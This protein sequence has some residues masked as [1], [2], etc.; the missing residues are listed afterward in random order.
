[1]ALARQTV[2]IPCTGGVD[3]KTT[4]Q[5]VQPGSFLAVV[6]GEYSKAGAINKR[7]GFSKLTNTGRKNDSTAATLAACE[8]LAAFRDELICIDGTDLWS[9]SAEDAHW[10]LQDQIPNATVTRETVH[11]DGNQ[12]TANG[13]LSINQGI[14]VYAW[15]A[16]DDL[17]VR[18]SIVDLTT[19]TVL[20]SD[21]TLNTV[22]VTASAYP[23]CVA[24]GNFVFVIY[25]SSAN[26]AYYFRRIDVTAVTAGVGV[27]TSL[28]TGCSTQVWDVSRGP[29]TSQFTMSYLVAATGLEVTVFSTAGAVVSTATIGAAALSVGV[30]ASAN[31]VY[32]GW[33]TAA[34]GMSYRPYSTA[35]AP[36]A[37]AL[38]LDAAATSAC[39]IGACEVTS[40]TALFM[41]HL[42]ANDRIK[43]RSVNNAGAAL[44]SVVQYCFRVE[45][46]SKPFV[47]GSQIFAWVKDKAESAPQI[48]AASGYLVEVRLDQTAASNFAQLRP[49]AQTA[50]RLAGGVSASTGRQVASGP[51][52]SENHATHEWWTVLDVLSAVGGT[53]QLQRCRAVFKNGE[54]WQSAELGDA[55]YLSG[56]CVTQYDGAQVT[57]VGFL[58]QL[59]FTLAQSVGGGALANGVYGY[60]VCREWFDRKGLR[61]RSA[62][63]LASIT[64]TGANNT[65]TL[66]ID[67]AAL[68]CRADY[69]NGFRPREQIVVYRTA[70]NL[71]IY[72]RQTTLAAHPATQVCDP[73]ATTGI[74]VVDD[75]TG[76]GATNEILY[77]VSGELPNDPPPSATHL[78]LHKNRLWVAGGEDPRKVYYTKEQIAGEPAQFS[79]DLYVLVR[80]YGEITALASLDDAL[81]VFKRSAIFAIFGDGPNARGVDGEFSAPQLVTTDAGCRDSRS[82][83]RTPDGVIFQSD[84]GLY[85]LDRA[86]QVSYIGAP[87]ETTEAGVACTSAVLVPSKNQVRIT[88]AEGIMVYDYAWKKWSTASYLGTVRSAVVSRQT[89]YWAAQSALTGGGIVFAEQSTYLDDGA[90]YSLTI[91][92]PWFSLDALQGVHRLWYVHCL[93]ERRSAHRVKLEVGYNYDS[94]WATLYH[95][96]E[97]VVTAWPREQ[98]RA[99][100]PRQSEQAWRFRWSDT[101]PA[102]VG[103]GEGFAGI[104]FGLE[105]GTEQASV[106]LP[107]AQSG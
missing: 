53:Y 39:L 34:A 51:A 73:M 21:L 47:H 48:T 36:L 90:Y 70:P 55:L 4:P 33:V 100:L 52:S 38:V 19:G 105:Y 102:V 22:A 37:A 54:S 63:T 57:E 11:H 50:Y 74:S 3:E 10:K 69:Y 42:P 43:W 14:A 41:W 24:A 16:P 1:M 96:T 6:N 107:A 86:R 61:H 62:P 93:G 94:A 35:L 85:L 104:A 28:L 44:L 75:A 71:T 13:D 103:S 26:S 83:V 106:R 27:E 89:Y 56:G 20:I 15:C 92:S 29:T 65:V 25:W 12:A 49:V 45:L 30:C 78:A 5:L 97:A 59:E 67:G 18:A 95:P 23:R 64:V 91:T 46:I 77:T 79:L 7:K 98:F 32:V 66:T 80:D 82:L 88:T 2:T 87:V 101:A 76:F 72:Y 84:R 17:A 99:H 81:I 60:A 40:S 8:R 9:Y 68:G 31:G 58:R